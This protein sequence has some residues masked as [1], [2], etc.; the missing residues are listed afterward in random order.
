VGSRLDAAAPAQPGDRSSPGASFLLP[1]LDGR[2]LFGAFLLTLL[3]MSAVLL[4]V[5]AIRPSYALARYPPIRAIESHRLHIA[6]L[7]F[8]LFFAAALL[9][10]VDRLQG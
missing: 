3:G 2:P 6:Q 4:T 9:F 10:L 5:A 8:G 7:G 1:V